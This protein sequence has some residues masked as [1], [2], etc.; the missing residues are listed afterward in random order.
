M[1]EHV[2]VI[3]AGNWGTALA[4]LL[5]KKGE[6]VVLWSFEPDVA[7]SINRDHANPRFLRGVPLA[8]TLRATADL[9]A[10]VRGARYLVS[11]SPSQHVRSIM[12]QAA[13]AL[14]SDV[15]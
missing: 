9:N 13:P 8:A 10:A 11:V 15:C 3:G 7:D 1:S 14:D 12:R 5:A 2:A 4:N 6:Q